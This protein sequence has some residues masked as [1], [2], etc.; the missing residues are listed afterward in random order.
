MRIGELSRLTGV[1]V[2]SL[3][4][5]EKTGL[6][7]SSRDG[8]GYREYSPLAVETVKTIVFYLRLGLSTEEIAGF[9]HCVLKSREAFCREVVPV[10]RQKL[11]ELTRQIEL[12]TNIKSNL[13]DRIRLIA[14]E[15]PNFLEEE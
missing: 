2:R 7:T 1:S 9:L 3:R 15:N 10:Y 8:N 14:A 6:L 5:Y 12:L 13:E 4:H 11:E